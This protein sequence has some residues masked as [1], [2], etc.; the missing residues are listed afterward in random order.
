VEEKSRN[1]TASSTWVTIGSFDGVHIGHQQILAALESGAKEYRG[2]AI[3]V[4]FYPH[5]AVVLR[6]I[7]EP[8]YLSTLAEKNALLR[9]YGA[10]EI[11]N[12]TFDRD[13]SRLSPRAFVQLLREKALFSRLLIGYDFRLGKDRTG[14]Q[15]A[16]KELGVEM[17]FTVDVIKPVMYEDE[18]VS[19]SRIRLAINEGNL[20]QANN[21]LGY[22]Y[23]V[24]GTVIH[25]DGRGKHIGLP[26]AN[27]LPWQS[28]L[29]PAAGVYAAYTEVGGNQHASVVNIG[30]RPTFY[31]PGAIQTIETHIFDF[32]QEIYDQK[33]GIH[34]IERLRPEEKFNGV[35][36][37]MAQIKCDIINAKEI[38]S[39]AAKPPN[40]PA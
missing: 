25:G 10:E 19:S 12:F 31:G 16:L 22:P 28:K 26:T 11:I 14:G 13:F 18:P 15:D 24:A 17:G 7:N 23:F 1:N 3:A 30:H 8:F 36:A 33:I 34:F 21:M 2:A 40:L 9:R 5:P 39:D 27:L 4:S 20:A 6:E 35:D 38:L 32:H 29:I 37:L